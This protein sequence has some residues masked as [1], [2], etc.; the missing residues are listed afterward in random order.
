MKNDFRGKNHKGEELTISILPT[1]LVTAMAK[2]KI[3]AT[4]TSDFKNEGDLVYL[5]GVPGSGLAGSEFAELYRVEVETLPSV[6][7]DLN[8]KMY[9]NNYNACQ[10]GLI[11]SCHDLS[12]GGLATAVAESSIGARL[13]V[14]LDI[15]GENDRIDYLFN[16]A[17]GRFLVSVKAENRD[18][19]EKQFSDVSFKH[20]GVVS[21][22]DQVE[23][24]M[25]GEKVL[26]AS[27]DKML[28]AW[29][30]GNLDE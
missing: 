10:L 20:I 9:K 14:K 5:L 13:G 16:E 30:R 24:T 1:L 11:N 29:K 28:S 23:V 6:N 21:S 27:M 12:D 18:A 15:K 8:K 25:D 19:F 2:S 22:S 4:V 26:T 7:P 17:P 3:T